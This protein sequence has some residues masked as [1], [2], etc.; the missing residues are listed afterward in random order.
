MCSREGQCPLGVAIPCRAAMVG[1]SS[2]L[3]R[4]LIHMRSIP[5]LSLCLCFLHA[6]GAGN[7]ASRGD[8]SAEN[9]V[10]RA[11]ASAEAASAPAG[12]AESAGPTPA[13]DESAAASPPVP[14]ACAP[15]QSAD[16]C[17]P[18]AA[19]VQKLCNGVYGEVALVMFRGGTPWRRLYLRGKTRSV[20]ASGGASV[21]GFLM[22]DEEV[23]VL[24]QRKDAEGGMQIGDG[25]GQYDV[26]RWDGSCA[27]LEGGEVTARRPRRPGQARIEWRWLSDAM[28]S[29]L[30]QD[31]G[32]KAAFLARKRECKGATQGVVSKACERFDRELCERVATYVRS[33][34]K[35]PPPEQHP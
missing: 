13:A 16:E 20:N 10:P 32:V 1:S 4:D 19:W 11:A 33:G 5:L 6:C 2:A 14:D 29:A 3:R 8:G 26:L 18:P 28:Q 21:E 30:L 9:A 25:S 17:T 23:L 12:D 22:R 24:R 35:L 34:P 7:A 15:E 31:E 27:S